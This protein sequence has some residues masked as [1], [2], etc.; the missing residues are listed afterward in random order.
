VISGN[1][2]MINSTVIVTGNV[3]FDH[4]SQIMMD[5]NSRFIIEGDLYLSADTTLVF[6][7]FSNT[8]IFCNSVH[9]NGT[10]YLMT[11]SVNAGKRLEIVMSK[12][13]VGSFDKINVTLL[14]IDHCFDAHLTSSE[15]DLYVSFEILNTCQSDQG[16]ITAVVISCCILILIALLVSLVVIYKQREK[17]KKQINRFKSHLTRNTTE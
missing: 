9:L 1:I 2:V 16:W 15:S 11:S 10:L 5:S 3:L 13:K 4:Q 17:K 6:T 7:E 8:S 14:D 12:S